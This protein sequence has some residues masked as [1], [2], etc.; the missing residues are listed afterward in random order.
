MTTHIYIL[1]YKGFELLDMAGPVSVFNTANKLAGRT[2]Y[3]IHLISTQGGL[4]ADSSGLQNMTSKAAKTSISPTDTLL[5]AGA[6]A[7]PLGLAIDDDELIDFIQRGGNK[8]G[9]CGSICSGSFLLAQ[10]GLLKNKTCTTHWIGMEQLKKIA[11]DSTVDENAMYTEDDEFWTSAGVT[12]GIDM[13]LAMLA[14]DQGEKLMGEVARHLVVYSHRPGKQSQFSEYLDLQLK[15]SAP[16]KEAITWLNNHLHKPIRVAQLAERA[17]MS[18]RSF[19]RKFCDDMG[20]TPAKYIENRRM[21][22]AKALMQKGALVKSLHHSLGY[23]SESAFRLVFEKTFGMSPHTFK[24]L[25][26]VK[27]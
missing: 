1:V 5:I 12:T 2:L 22:K 24:L 21:E 20:M 8:A 14:K 23:R 18:E 7:T 9:R 15:T 25:H 16:L 17:N 3:K 6:S 13:A 27:A 26:Q 19:Y 11:V 4:I 10:A